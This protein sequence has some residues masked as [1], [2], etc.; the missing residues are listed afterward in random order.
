MPARRGR[1][2]EAPGERRRSGARCEQRLLTAAALNRHEAAD[3]ALYLTRRGV[4][5]DAILEES[6]S[7]ETVGNAL[8][9]RLLHTDPRGLRTLA[10]VNNRFHMP[11]TRAVFGHVFRVPPTSESEPEAAY[12]LEYYEV[13]DHLPADVL[14]ARLRKEAKSTPV[15]AEGGS[16]RAQTRTLRELAG[17]LWRENTAYAT[18][19][20]LEERL[21]P[22]PEVLKSY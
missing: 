7:L 17:W 11:R 14:Q 9:T 8:F 3:N 4:P 15:F 13:E 16:W 6:A 19:R 18:K 2:R 20:L 10:V 1:V 21:P 22:D 5:P 12:E